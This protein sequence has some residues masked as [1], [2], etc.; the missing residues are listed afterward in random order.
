VSGGDSISPTAHYTGYVWARNG[1]S[2]PELQTAEGRVLFESLRG[3]MAVNRALGGATLE[4]Y[5]LARHRT[6]DAVLERAIEEHGIGQVIEVA[7]GM[8]PRGWRF[9]ERYGERLTYVEGDLPEMAARKRRALERIGSL[10]ERHRVVEIDALRGDGPGSLA[11]VA[12]ELDPAAGLAIIT[13][14]LITYLPRER[15]EAMWRRFA[16]VLGRFATGRYLSDVRL[17][18]T[19]TARAKAFRV[20]LAAFVRGQVHVHFDDA[21]ELRA[22]LRGAG[23][24]GAQVHVADE[25]GAAGSRRAHIIEASTT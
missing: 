23:F 16:A 4:E 8:S 21:E 20:M 10:G 6:I 7:C 24:A 2:H 15:V 18:G 22:A 1:L 11:A 13:E 14:G 9:A 12:A 3:A 5:L 17:R 19:D 25:P